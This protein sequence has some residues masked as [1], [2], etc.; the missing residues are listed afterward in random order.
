MNLPLT[1]E[2]LL[3]TL[4]KHLFPKNPYVIETPAMACNRSE[5]YQTAYKI[6]SHPEDILG[7]KD[8]LDPLYSK[9][10]QSWK[11]WENREWKGYV[12]D[13]FIAYLN[14]RKDQVICL[15]G[16]ESQR[17]LALPYTTRFDGNYANRV[18]YALRGVMIKSGTLLTLTGDPKKFTNI[19]QM[20]RAEKVSWNRIRNQIKLR[21]GKLDYLMVQE[22]GAKND[23]PHLHVLIKDIVLTDED[24]RWIKSLWAPYVAVEVDT[25]EIEDVYAAG[26]VLKYLKKTFDKAGNPILDGNGWAYFVTNTKFYS[27]SESLKPADDEL[28]FEEK[29]ALVY[30]Y[31]LIGDGERYEYLGCCHHS[32]FNG[33]DPEFFT[34]EWLTAHN[35]YRD[36]IWDVWRPPLEA[37]AEDVPEVYVTPKNVVAPGYVEETDMNA[38]W[39]SL[40]VSDGAFGRR[41]L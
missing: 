38:A 33:A 40:S 18:K 8:R 32:S 41:C 13:E 24:E 39:L 1:L 5:E 4:V 34:D 31:L 2:K 20:A 23:L 7:R 30:L 26:Y 12:R 14:A 37:P 25:S 15:R 28:S 36:P 22:F 21:F 17:A 35:W 10:Q 29:V 16:I 3:L 11:W 6:A 19:I 9:T 27:I